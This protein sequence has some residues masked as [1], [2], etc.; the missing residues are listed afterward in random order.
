MDV[1]WRI[2]ANF[3]S[4]SEKFDRKTLSWALVA[5]E[6]NEKMR[7][8]RAW[9]VFVYARLSSRRCCVHLNDKL[10]IGEFSPIPQQ[11]TTQRKSRKKRKKSGSK[12][13]GGNSKFYGSSF[14]YLLISNSRMMV[15]N[16]ESWNSWETFSSFI[17]FSAIEENRLHVVKHFR[18]RKGSLWHAMNG[19][20]SGWDSF[21]VF[22]SKSEV[23]MGD[24]SSLS[25]GKKRRYFHFILLSSVWLIKKRTK[26][27]KGRDERIIIR[28]IIVKINFYI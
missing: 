9:K 27:E 16:E 4:I 24:I 10:L 7:W 20:F 1:N 23:E 25:R 12:Y 26:E 19:R 13:F 2:S 21:C 15:I 6:T 5:F 3:L 14:F 28:G 18:E 8:N 22:S 11:Q 17:L